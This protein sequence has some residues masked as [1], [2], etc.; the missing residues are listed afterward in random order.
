MR[1][2][3]APMTCGV[4]Y[5]KKDWFLLCTRF[6][7]C[8]FAPWMPIHRVVGMLKEIWGSRICQFIHKEYAKNLCNLDVYT[9]TL[10][11]HLLICTLC[12]L[13]IELTRNIFVQSCS[14][15][16]GIVLSTTWPVPSK[17]ARNVPASNPHEMGGV[18]NFPF[19]STMRLPIVNS[20][21][22]PL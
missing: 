18:N 21:S 17:W 22:S 19:N 8:L 7:Q 10:L 15:R 6:V 1:H 13:R 20:V 9:V 4:T 12:H 3:V 2:Y 5:A 14:C 11:T 16:I